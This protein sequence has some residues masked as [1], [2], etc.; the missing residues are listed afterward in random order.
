[1]NGLGAWIMYDMMSDAI[2]RDRMMAQRGYVV[3][4][5]NLEQGLWGKDLCVFKW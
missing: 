1:M 5:K 2:M 3:D 4:R